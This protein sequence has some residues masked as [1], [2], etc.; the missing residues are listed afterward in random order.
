[1]KRPGGP[2]NSAAGRLAPIR[3][4]APPAAHHTCMGNRPTQSEMTRKFPSSAV[5]H[6][7]A[8]KYLTKANRFKADAENMAQLSDEFSGNGVAVL[9]VHAAI[10]YGDPTIPLRILRLV[11]LVM[12]VA[13]KGIDTETAALRRRPNHIGRLSVDDAREDTVDLLECPA[14]Q[15]VRREKALG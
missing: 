12:V 7:L 8:A 14:P 6:S 1:M 11:L 2:I 5:D 10:A 4:R 9:C 13:L 3:N 15:P